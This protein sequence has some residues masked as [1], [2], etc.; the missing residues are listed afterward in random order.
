MPLENIDFNYHWLLDVKHMV[1][2]TYF[3]R[4]KP[5]SPHMILFP[6]SSKGSCICTFPETGQH[7]PQPLMDQ[8][9]FFKATEIQNHRTMQL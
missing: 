3:F 9:V 7:I 2:V 1:T 4:G 8:M 6:I 5:L